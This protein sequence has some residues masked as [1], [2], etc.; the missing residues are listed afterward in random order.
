MSAIFPHKVRQVIRAIQIHL[1]YHATSLDT[2]V[3]PDVRIPVKPCKKI[4]NDWTIWTPKKH[5]LWDGLFDERKTQ[6][7]RHCSTQFHQRVS[8]WTNCGTGGMDAYSLTSWRVLWIPMLEYRNQAYG[9]VTDV[10]LVMPCELSW[11]E[12]ET[13]FGACYPSVYRDLSCLEIF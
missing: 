9:A 10:N 7:V 11:S 2:F 12:P 5:A 4:D 6:L 13:H 3:H 8:P 1:H